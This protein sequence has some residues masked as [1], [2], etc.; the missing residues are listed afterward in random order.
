[1]AQGRKMI[2]LA[3]GVLALFWGLFTLYSFLVNRFQG[4]GD[5]LVF[6]LVFYA[7][8]LA[9]LIGGFVLLLG[10]SKKKQKR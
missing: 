3:A 5:V 7:V 9:A 2:R 4:E 8:G 10:K 6:R 1:M